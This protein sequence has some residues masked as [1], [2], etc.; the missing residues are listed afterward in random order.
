MSLVIDITPVTAESAHAPAQLE[1]YLRLPHWD[2]ASLWEIEATG[3]TLN[4]K[5]PRGFEQS[6]ERRCESVD[7][8]ESQIRDGVDEEAKGDCLVVV[9]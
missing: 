8:G 6:I 7:H 5:L 4:L 3:Q 9:S 2:S 1:L